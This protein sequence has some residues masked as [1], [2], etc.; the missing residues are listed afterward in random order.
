MPYLKLSLEKLSLFT[1]I[2]SKSRLLWLTK[3]ILEIYTLVN[4]SSIIYLCFI[5]DFSRLKTI[6]FDGSSTVQVLLRGKKVICSF[7]ST[8]YVFGSPALH[9]IWT[10]DNISLVIYWTKHIQALLNSF[11]SGTIFIVYC[12]NKDKQKNLAHDTFWNE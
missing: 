7:F 8:V 5:T 12:V 3:S 6:F 1:I 2:S 11:T 9:K 10:V 4:T